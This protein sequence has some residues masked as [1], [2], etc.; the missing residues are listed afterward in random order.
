VLP[1][2]HLHPLTRWA[3]ALVLVSSVGFI[4]CHSRLVEATIDNQTSSA[5]HLLEVDYPSAS[6]GTQSLAAG[7]QYHYRFKIQGSGEVKISF[8]DALG[9][10]HTSTGPA[11]EDGQ[12]GTLR[13]TIDRQNAIHFEPRLIGSR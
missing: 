8:T 1:P 9:K 10:L 6:F 13:I 3:I 7:A 11:L 5:M 12:E 2:F 4:G